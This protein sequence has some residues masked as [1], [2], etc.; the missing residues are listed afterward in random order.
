MMWPRPSPKLVPPAMLTPYSV[1]SDSLVSPQFM[2][3]LTPSMRVFMRKLT[4]PAT[5]SE[6]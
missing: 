5:A 4:T 3:T 1:P 2:S 6:P